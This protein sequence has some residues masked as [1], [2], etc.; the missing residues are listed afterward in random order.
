M[1]VFRIRA[2]FC[3]T[4]VASALPHFRLWISFAFSCTAL[5]E[6]GAGRKRPSDFFFASAF[7]GLSCSGTARRT[8]AARRHFQ[9]CLLARAANM[10]EMTPGVAGPSGLLAAEVGGLVQCD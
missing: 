1:A 6:T 7:T 10:E 9:A 5:D 4:T 8:D 3:F 2:L